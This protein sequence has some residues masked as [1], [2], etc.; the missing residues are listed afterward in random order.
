MFMHVRGRLLLILGVFLVARLRNCCGRNFTDRT[1]LRQSPAP[2]KQFSSSHAI[3]RFIIII[4][5]PP[6]PGCSQSDTGPPSTKTLN[7]F[8]SM[9]AGKFGVST[10]TVVRMPCPTNV[11]DRAWAN[12]VEVAII[13]PTAHTYKYNLISLLPVPTVDGN[14][15]L[16]K[17]HTQSVRDTHAPLA[18][19]KGARKIDAFHGATLSHSIMPTPVAGT[20]S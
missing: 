19:S 10:D 5:R 7:D 1:L 13:S 8:A 11:T 16:N 9:S 14:V 6:N 4:H 12:A 3:R 17:W 18:P 20:C 15:T 2:R